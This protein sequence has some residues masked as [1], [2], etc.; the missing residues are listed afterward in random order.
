M[1]VSLFQYKELP[2][3]LKCNMAMPSLVISRLWWCINH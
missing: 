1:T 2:K 3:L